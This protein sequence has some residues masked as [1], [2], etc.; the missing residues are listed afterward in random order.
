MKHY[1]LR[2]TAQ[3]IKALKMKAHILLLACI[4][5]LF[6]GCATIVDG[7]PKSVRISSNPQGASVAIYDRRERKVSVETTPVTVFLKRGGFF[8]PAR[9]RLDFVMSGFQSRGI[10]IMPKVNPWYFGNFAFLAL[11]P[12]G[13]LVDPA[14][15]A[16]WTISPRT[17]SCTLNPVSAP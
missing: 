4:P 12:I 14:T 10:Q 6:A 17:I 16:M 7:G 5:I 15:G 13:F 9:Y 11:S 8:R 3:T 2:I 1:V